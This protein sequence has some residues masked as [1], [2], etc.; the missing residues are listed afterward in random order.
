MWVAWSLLTYLCQELAE[1]RPGDGSS[2][3]RLWRCSC[4]VLCGV[5]LVVCLC[6]T[7][8]SIYPCMH[9][10]IH[11]SIELSIYLLHCPPI[12]LHLHIYMCL[13]I[14]LHTYIHTYTPVYIPPY[15]SMPIK[16]T[17]RGKPLFSRTWARNSPSIK[18]TK[19]PST[20]PLLTVCVCD[21][22]LFSRTRARTVCL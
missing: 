9:P 7:Y 18:R 15:I 21:L 20:N 5:L 12:Q 17:V 13:F 4:R 1:H 2:C 8:P 22:F 19:S 10:S 3:G 11:L 6:V 16:M 14:Y